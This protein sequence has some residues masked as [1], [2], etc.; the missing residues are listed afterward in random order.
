MK[1]R[2]GYVLWLIRS[3]IILQNVDKAQLKLST[4]KDNV[5]G[6]SLPVFETR[7]E[8][9]DSKFIVMQWIYNIIYNVFGSAQELWDSFMNN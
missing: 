4:K 5:A 1:L 8:G 3:Q 2:E 7:S 6:V 9:T